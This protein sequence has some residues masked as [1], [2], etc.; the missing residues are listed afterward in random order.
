[1]Q[2]S[3]PWDPWLLVVENSRLFAQRAHSAR[4]AP[5]ASSGALGAV[6]VQCGHSAHKLHVIAVALLGPTLP[7]QCPQRVSGNGGL[8]PDDTGAL[9]Y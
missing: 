8:P 4:C 9:L 3:G 7:S 2:N 6:C 1:M 5:K